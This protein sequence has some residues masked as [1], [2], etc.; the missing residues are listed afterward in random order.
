MEFD[1]ERFKE[2]VMKLKSY[3]KRTVDNCFAG[4][5]L[6]LEQAG[7]SADE[8]FEKIDKEIGEQ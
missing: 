3:D 2:L 5:L 4:V 8:L 1:S 6:A 7:Q